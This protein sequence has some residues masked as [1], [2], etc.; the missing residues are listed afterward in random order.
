MQKNLSE[1]GLTKCHNFHMERIL[2]CI[3][4]PHL[5]ILDI[6]D[7]RYASDSD[8]INLAEGSPNLKNVNISWCNN[9]NCAGLIGLFKNCLKL[10]MVNLTGVKDSRD[11][12][13]G[14]YFSELR[15]N[16]DD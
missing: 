2:N 14:E 15:D 12:I 8:L 9:I 11:E 5:L 3:R 13:F 16:F 10:E 7:S 4:S 1:L 6:T